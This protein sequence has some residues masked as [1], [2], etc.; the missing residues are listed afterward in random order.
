MLT[1][2]VFA[3]LHAQSYNAIAEERGADDRRSALWQLAIMD[4]IVSVLVLLRTSRAKLLG[5]VLARPAGCKH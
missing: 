1:D 3:E 5:F 2:C 4:R